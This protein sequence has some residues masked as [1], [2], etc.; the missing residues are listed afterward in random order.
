VNPFR[1]TGQHLRMTQRPLHDRAEPADAPVTVAAI[2]PLYNGEL[3]VEQAVRSVLAQSV[4][5]DEIIVVD[6]GST[7]G[8]VD[9]VRALAGEHPIKIISQLNAGQSA[10]RNL[11]I[12]LTSCDYVALIDQDDLWY[13]NHLEEL[14]RAVRE[15]RGLRLG[16]AYT[17][18]D[19]ID[20]DGRMVSRDFVERSHTDNPKRDL[21][22]VLAQ[23]VVIQPSATLISRAAILEVGG[24]DPRLSGYEDDDLFLRIFLANFDN[25]FVPVPTSQWRIHATSSGGSDRMINSLRIYGEKLIEMFPNDEW[26]GFYYRSDVIAPR[27]INTWL[28]MYVRAARYKDR[29]RMRLYAREARAMLKY[30]RPR[31]RSNYASLLFILRQPFFIRFWSATVDNKS[32]PLEPFIAVARRMMQG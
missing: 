10:A 6:D 20:L 25:I 31:A 17:D 11:A 32:L 5:P 1:P 24:F 7:D 15:H 9:I 14:V 13:P 19:D 22:K 23:G 18:F 16:W 21:I 26:R 30:L 28:Q 12:S 2:L 29:A 27:I 8:G 3:W 4:A